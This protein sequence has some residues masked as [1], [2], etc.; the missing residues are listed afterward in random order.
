M[1]RNPAAASVP[2]QNSRVLII[3]AIITAATTIG[4]AF[5]GVFPQLRNSDNKRY[6]QLQQE[7]ADFRKKA[8]DELPVN[9]SSQKKMTVTGTV[10]DEA[11]QKR[12]PGVEVYL[13]PEGNNYL[14][15]K[16]DDNGNFTL[17]G[18]PD[19]VYSIIVRESG[20]R[21][22]KGLLDDAGDEVK[23][24]GASIRYRIRR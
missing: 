13:L 5:I 8:G 14:T 10:F 15:A 6:E 22:G 9:P 7:F 18:V 4:V 2:P 24:I 16:T 1:H 23:V 3:T 19:G 17:G 20:G 12:L 21:S 11:A